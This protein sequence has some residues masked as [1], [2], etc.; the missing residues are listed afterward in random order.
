MS[1]RDSDNIVVFFYNAYSCGKFVSNILAHNKNFVP[2]FALD[3]N[4][5]A[6]PSKETYDAMSLSE[7]TDS[8]HDSIMLTLPQKEQTLNWLDYEL[9]CW[10][11]WG[12]LADDVDINTPANPKAVWLLQQGVKCFLMVH[13]YQHMARIQTVFPNCQV[14]KF[15]NDQAINQQSKALKVSNT[16]TRWVNLS[17]IKTPFIDFDIGTMF[18]REVFFNHIDQLML[19]LGIQDRSLDSR[20]NEY[21]QQYCNLYQ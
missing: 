1:W 21:Y 14:V 2:Q 6:H 20:V 9:G 10:N 19:D 4:L 11:F 13:E 18:D 12:F 3:G 8:K 7:L 5:P 15:V 16:K 17:N